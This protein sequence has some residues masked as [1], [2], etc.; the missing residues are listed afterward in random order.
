MPFGATELGRAYIVVT[1]DPKRLYASLE[2][3]KGRTAALAASIER[4]FGG[5]RRSF[6]HIGA[7]LAEIE[8][9]FSRLARAVAPFAIAVGGLSGLGIKLAADFERAMADVAAVLGK[10]IDAIQDLTEYAKRMGIETVFSAREAAEAMYYL[11]SAGYDAKEIMAA[12]R[13]AL[14]LAAATQADLAFATETVVT[15][16]AGFRYESDEAARV[17]NTFAAA[18]SGSHLQ[19]SSS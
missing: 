3:I 11:A 8:A 14:D 10:P 18:I 16:L 7:G 2:G 1:A 6:R 13:P 5:L 17:A 12:L 15:A 9:G 4:S 19:C